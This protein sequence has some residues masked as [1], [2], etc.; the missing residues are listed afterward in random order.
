MA[1]ARDYA[2]DLLRVVLHELARR[3]LF[4]LIDHPAGVLGS[5]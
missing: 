3:R 4:S 5:E 2:A 1:T